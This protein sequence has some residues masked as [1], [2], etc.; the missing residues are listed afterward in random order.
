MG[1][2]AICHSIGEH[3]HTEFGNQKY[4]VPLPF[5]TASSEGAGN[6]NGTK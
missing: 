4:P 5:L 1:P 3:F 6:G 2:E